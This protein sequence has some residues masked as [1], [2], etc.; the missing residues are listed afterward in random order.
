LGVCAAEGVLGKRAGSA[1]CVVDYDVFEQRAFCYGVRGDLVDERDV[2]D[3][4]GGDPAA[5]IAN[6]DCI[7]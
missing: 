6:D 4:L 1:L 2:I 5:A 3:H 7:A